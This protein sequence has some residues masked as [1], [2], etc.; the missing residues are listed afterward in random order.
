[1]EKSGIAAFN[2]FRQAKKNIY[3]S[4]ALLKYYMFVEYRIFICDFTE[5]STR[6]KFKHITEDVTS[7]TVHF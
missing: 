2:L 4:L 1:M 6:M 5:I 7:S 3:S